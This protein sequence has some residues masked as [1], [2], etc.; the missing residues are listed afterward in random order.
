MK[1]YRRRDSRNIP[2]Q[3]RGARAEKLAGTMERTRG[4]AML[5]DDR[6]RARLQATIAALRYW[7]PSIADSAAITETSSDEYWEIDVVPHVRGAC[8][9]E[10]VLRTD[11]F[12]DLVVAGET[13][14]DE[15]TDNLDLFVPFV[16]AIARGEVVQ[17]TY[18]AAATGLPLAVETIVDMGRDGSWHRRRSID[19]N[20]KGEALGDT[21]V[22]TQAFLPYRRG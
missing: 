1:L 18:A 7:C 11:G 19:T 3:V 6:Y 12:H 15:P 2:G 13:Y 4:I 10:L 17:K 8:P 22:T 21:I 9:F 14:E 16:S 20:L 5:I